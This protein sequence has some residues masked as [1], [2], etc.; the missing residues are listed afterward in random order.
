MSRSFRQRF[1]TG[2]GKRFLSEPAMRE[3]TGSR[4]V[5]HGGSKTSFRDF[6]GHHAAT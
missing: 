3:E 5:F 4:R 2:I 1:L 6:P